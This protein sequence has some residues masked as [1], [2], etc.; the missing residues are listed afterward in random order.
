MYGI[1]LKI[2]PQNPP[3]FEITNVTKRI[4]TKS[5]TITKIPEIKSCFNLSF[6]SF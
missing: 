5:G 4:V 6:I 2:N 3:N 1:V